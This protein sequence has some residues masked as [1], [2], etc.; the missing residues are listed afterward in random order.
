LNPILKE[1]NMTTG[2]KLLTRNEAAELLG[3]RPQTLAVWHITGKYGLPVVKVGRS[4]R[5]RLAD[6]EKWIAAR[7]VGAAAE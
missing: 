3:V 4:V 1:R 5:Y 2:T 6:L 7:T